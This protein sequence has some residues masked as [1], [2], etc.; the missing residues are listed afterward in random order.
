MKCERCPVAIKDG[1]LFVR[2]ERAEPPD[3]GSTCKSLIPPT[4]AHLRCPSPWDTDDPDAGGNPTCQVCCA[5]TEWGVCQKC[6]PTLWR[7]LP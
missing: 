3:Q 1:D 6:Q 7:L 2:V 5:L 4:V